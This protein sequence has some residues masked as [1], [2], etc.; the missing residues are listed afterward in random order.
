MIE[1]SFSPAWER[2]LTQFDA[3][4]VRR[5]VAAK[6]RTAYGLDA[7][8]LAGWASARGDD[9]ARI[10]VRTL[11]RY[12]A[13]LSAG[14]LSPASVARKLAS[15]RALFRVL[16]E[17]RERA[18][19][20]ADLLSA[21]KRPRRLPHVL[22]PAE[23]AS[24]LDRIPATTPLELRDRALFELA[25]ASGLRAEELVTL[26]VGSLDFD[27][28]AVR[29]EGK[30]GKTRI[31]PVGEPA[32][33]ALERY[34]ARGRP[35]LRRRVRTPVGCSSRS[36]DEGLVPPTCA[37]DCEPGRGRRR[38]GSRRWPAPTRTPCAT[39]SPPTCSRVEPISGRSR[40]SS[41]TRP[42]PRRRSTLG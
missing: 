18:D 9:P 23:V 16:V 15:L 39:R 33:A 26:G 6:T 35:A 42:S 19:N 14:G 36:P 21:P 25:Y 20:P 4:L 5:A 41:A 32:M 11:R 2:A 34:L 40:S 22:R 10:D 28:E 13:A 24:L 17:Q 29:V 1:P 12:A 7:R 3:D 38:H 30:G 27:A 8:G 31:V 37:G